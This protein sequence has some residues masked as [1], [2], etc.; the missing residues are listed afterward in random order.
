MRLN[1]QQQQRRQQ[2]TLLRII[3]GIAVF[4]TATWNCFPSATAFVPLSLVYRT[5]S[6]QRTSGLF[7]VENDGSD[8]DDENVP[9]VVQL[10]E[11]LVYIQ[12]LEERNKAQIDSFVDEE[13]QWESMEEYERELLSSKE[14]IEKQLN[15]LLAEE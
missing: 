12:A 11:K 3:L 15:E 10:Q 9:L 13:H 1:E 7:A 4:A 14:D 5:T 6:S 8:L 2:Q